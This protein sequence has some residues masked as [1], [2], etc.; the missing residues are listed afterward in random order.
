LHWSTVTLGY[1]SYLAV[2][3]WL[4]PMSS[5]ARGRVLSAAA[6]TWAAFAAATRSGTD[7]DAL[8]PALLVALPALILLLGYWLSGLFFVHPQPAIERGLL[9]L[10]HAVLPRVSA[11]Q[12]SQGA[13]RLLLE[14]LELSYLLVYALLPAGAV[15]IAFAGEAWDVARFWTVVLLA[16]FA[17]YAVLPWIQ[18][19]PPRVVEDPVGS[20]PAIGVRRLNLA[21]AR[22]ASI[23]ANTL[24]SA[25]T[26][27]AVAAALCVIEASPNV[28]AAFLVVATS[29]AA[30]TVAGRYHYLLDS[31]LG[32][33]V[34]AAA[35]AVVY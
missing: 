24:P 11:V 1:V 32:A 26:A 14:Y 2:V 22:R 33:L 25:H 31:I 23:Q 29:I 35:W 34:G 28:G 3:S 9:R 8:S 12:W 30:A 19:R 27:G 18:T 7:L 6:A 20:P 4:R 13:P 10:D 15:V 16:E 17:C 5:G 21:I